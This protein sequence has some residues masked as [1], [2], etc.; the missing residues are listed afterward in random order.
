MKAIYKWIL[1]REKALL[2]N[3]VIIDANRI[4]IG[5]GE[6]QHILPTS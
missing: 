3:E 4:L 2:G 5:I 6:S 1:R